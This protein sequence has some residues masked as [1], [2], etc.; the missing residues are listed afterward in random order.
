M[1]SSTFPSSIELLFFKLSG[2]LSPTGKMPRTI[3]S[4]DD[5][6]VG[7]KVPSTLVDP[8]KGTGTTLS[9]KTA[10]AGGSKEG[11][12]GDDGSRALVIGSLPK[13]SVAKKLSMK[14][15]PA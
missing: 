10:P 5:A 4:G 13:F 3:A 8:S 2:F 6:G 15:A 14:R 7:S 12:A 1:Q 9:Q 11:D